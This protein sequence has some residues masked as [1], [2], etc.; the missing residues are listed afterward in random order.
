MNRRVFKKLRA[1][2]FF[3]CG[4]P[5]LFA[6]GLSQYMGTAE[7]SGEKAVVASTSW[8]AAIAE[9]AGARDVRV[10]APVELRHPPEYELRPSDLAAAGRADI[11]IYAGWE[12]F[13]ARLAETAGGAGV[14]LV[15]VRTSNTPESLMAE[16]ERLARILG[17]EDRF[18]A[19]QKNFGPLAADLRQRVLAAW[20]GGRVVAEEAFAGF[21]AWLGLEVLGEYGPAE[22]SPALIFNLAQTAPALVIDNYHIPSGRP[23]AEAAGAAYV[24]LINFPGRDGTKTIEDLFRHNADALVRAAAP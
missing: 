9:A 4:S 19:W 7:E 2:F 3:F 15:Q 14:Q 21:A 16:A 1:A 17:T 13:A 22:P 8:T 23:I 20:P 6:G 18:A 10:L 12:T 5:A 11:I 24:E